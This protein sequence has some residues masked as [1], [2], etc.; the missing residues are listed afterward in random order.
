MSPRPRKASDDQVF[1]AARNAMARH[2]PHE[3][4]LA[5]IAREAGLTPGA[6]VQRFGGKRELLQA[7]AARFSGGAAEMFQMLRAADP[8]PLGALRLWVRGMAG[9]APTPTALARNLAWLHVDL[10]DPDL[11][12]HLVRHARTQQRELERLVQDA[13]AARE[14]ARDA[15]PKRLA[16]TVATV[17][18]GSLM[19][20]ATYR[21]GSAARWLLEDVDAVL[22][23]WRGETSPKP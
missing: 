20:W 12:L 18:S 11:R 8:S 9:L 17:V 6:L 22:A 4:T 15:N 1:I 16:R 2:G 13:I 3:L 21:Q 19:T 14:L 23:P 10:T 7:L 5:H